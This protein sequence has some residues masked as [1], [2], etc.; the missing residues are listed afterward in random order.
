M[1]VLLIIVLIVIVISLSL[2]ERM[3]LHMF[4]DKAWD[5]TESS[6]PSPFSQ[7]LAGL[8][9]TAGGIYLSL[10]LL[11]TFL[12]VQL[13]DRIHLGQVQMEPLAAV[14]IG[15]AIIQPFVLKLFQLIRLIRRF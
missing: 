4:R 9:G 3:R 12:E 15:L 1:L 2:R 7:A 13:P 14:S 11:F 8:V 6:R 5:L 10:V